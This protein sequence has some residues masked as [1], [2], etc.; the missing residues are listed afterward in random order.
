MP[1]SVSVQVDSSATVGV[2]CVLASGRSTSAS[3][4]S[5]PAVVSTRTR[6]RSP[7]SARTS[8][9]SVSSV[10]VSVTAC[11]SAPTVSREQPM[12]FRRR[13]AIR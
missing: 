8:Q 10:S 11:G 13:S 12:V 1:D 2:H 3:G 4:F 6:S 5:V 9:Q 7:A